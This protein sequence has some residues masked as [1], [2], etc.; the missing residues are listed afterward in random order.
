MSAEGVTIEGARQLSGLLE[1]VLA[2]RSTTP[3]AISEAAS[4][5]VRAAV[6]D[7]PVVRCPVVRGKTVWAVASASV[8]VVESP[9]WLGTV[10][11]APEQLDSV[12]ITPEQAPAPTWRPAVTI[13]RAHGE[14][15]RLRSQLEPDGSRR[16]RSR[17]AAARRLAK[18]LTQAPGLHLAHGAPESPTFVVLVPDVSRPVGRPFGDGGRLDV[19]P[20]ATPGLPGALRI[21]VRGRLDDAEAADLARRISPPR[22]EGSGR[23]WA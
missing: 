18:Q 7:R 2:G 16:Y 21:T 6:A 4:P 13:V 8:A 1:A 17:T 14:W 3:V 11:A 9:N 12:L 23:R 22:S 10:E 5:I 15:R 20:V 19:E